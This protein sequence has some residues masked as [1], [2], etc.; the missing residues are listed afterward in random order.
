MWDGKLVEEVVD[1]LGIEKMDGG[2]RGRKT[3]WRYVEVIF[4]AHIHVSRSIGLDLESNCN[5]YFLDF[6]CKIFIRVVPFL[7]LAFAF[8]C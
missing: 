7:I 6:I 3:V 1:R 4:I 2:K 8:M 5:H